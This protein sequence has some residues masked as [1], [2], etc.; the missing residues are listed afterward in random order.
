MSPIEL[1]ARGL[2]NQNWQDVSDGY[3]ALTGVHI[4][5]PAS[6]NND[7]VS[8]LK[9]VLSQLEGT[10]NTQEQDVKPTAA[11]KA[12][13]GRAPKQAAPKAKKTTAT[14]KP[15]M[16]FISGDVAMSEDEAK[17]N[18][19]IA[20]QTRERPV[21]KNQTQRFTC[22]GCNKELPL[23]AISVTRIGENNRG[24]QLCGKCKSVRR[25]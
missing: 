19:A 13:R 12:K 5:I 17:W 16:E 14:T 22:S 23:S 6:T 7:P 18:D 4:N 1:I 20:H 15:V 21:R 25:K 2:K 24:D 3:S 8:L 11:P 10:A 9:R